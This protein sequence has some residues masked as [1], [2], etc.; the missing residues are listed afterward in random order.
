MA[1]STV[2]VRKVIRAATDILENSLEA[3]GK[4]MGSVCGQMV[5]DTWALGKTVNRMDVVKID[6]LMA[7]YTLVNLVKVS[8]MAMV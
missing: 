4:V 8:A 2:S 3:K 6:I 7:M 1:S 5:H